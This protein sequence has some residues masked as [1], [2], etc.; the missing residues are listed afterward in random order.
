MRTVPKPS[1]CGLPTPNLS[2]GSNSITC[3]E[4]R[5]SSKK[6]CQDP[7]LRLSEATGQAGKACNDTCYTGSG[8]PKTEDQYTVSNQDAGK[9]RKGR[10]QMSLLQNRQDGRHL[11]HQGQC[12]PEIQ[13]HPYKSCPIVNSEGYR[14][15]GG[16][17]RDMMEHQSQN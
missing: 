12:Q 2:G 10:L 7:A 3:P 6:V 15:Y 4:H 13:A 9:T 17:T 16:L 1:G 8:T 5:D 11:R 14:E